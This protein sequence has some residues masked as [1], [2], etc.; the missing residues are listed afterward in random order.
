MEDIMTKLDMAAMFI[1]CFMLFGSVPM[2]V[3]GLAIIGV[4]VY[5]SNRV[6]D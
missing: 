3:I 5:R 2:A 6:G 4:V 1:G